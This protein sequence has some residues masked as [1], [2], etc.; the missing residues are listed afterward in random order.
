MTGRIVIGPPAT[1]PDGAR[2]R[3]AALRRE[4][5][6][7]EGLLERLPN[8]PEPLTAA[9][10]AAPARRVP[11]IAGSVPPPPPPGFRFA[12][13]GSLVGA[14]AAVRSGDVS[15][16]E[17]VEDALRRA[18]AASDLNA[19][20]LLRDDAVADARR[21]DREG[22][23]PLRG[24]P[25]SVKDIVDV[26]GLPTT[27]GSRFPRSPSVSA[28]AWARLEAA[29]AVLLGKNNLVEFAFGVHGDNPWFG[30]TKNPRDPAR[31]PGGSSSGSAAAVAA[32]IGY[33]SVGSDTGGSIR[34]P[35]ALTGIFG[36]KP[37]YG[38]V[39]RLGV[40]ALSWS[41]DHVG[42]LAR[43]AAD[44]ELLWNVMGPDGGAAQEPSPALR[45]RPLQG[46]RVGVPRNHF[47]T[48]L[49]RPAREAAERALKRLGDLGA[50]P[51]AVEIPE[52]ECASVARTAIAFAEAARYHAVRLR[53]R[54][55]AISPEVATLLRAGARL[56]ASDYLTALRIRRLVTDAFDRLFDDVD[57]LL[58][59][60]APAGAALAGDGFL[61]TGEALRTGYMRF[62]APF[63]LTGHPAL[64]LPGG[65]D[66]AGMPLGV[67]L[68]GPAG[69]ERPVL[70]LAQFLAPAEASSAAAGPE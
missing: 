21:R 19:F 13:A 1:A 15:S 45:T 42:P 31:I 28:P 27:S 30:R 36:L 4:I 3:A 23:G 64:S 20:I 7:L 49:V 60:T 22:E 5:A 24:V 33:G 34:I 66:E 47:F 25:L 14:A 26:A 55:E 12:M 2:D 11:N 62:V 58:T 32:G 9:E 65:L 56:T 48:D 17:L 10:L 53:G 68:V 41:L 39:S 37:T 63:D 43:S 35:A 40:T 57:V 67:Q 6:E 54:P 18:E 29:G 38:A 44:L 70:R 61:P 50:E 8:P 69:G 51:V 59:S 52:V 46:V 16:V